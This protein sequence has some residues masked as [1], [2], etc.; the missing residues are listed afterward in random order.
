MDKRSSGNNK[1]KGKGKDSINGVQP[2]L[3]ARRLVIANTIRTVFI[4]A[5]HPVSKRL[6]IHAA[7]TCGIAVA[8]TVIDRRK[9][10]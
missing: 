6:A 3:P 10:Q 2:A 4:E 8:H 5:L 7:D 1:K 9:R